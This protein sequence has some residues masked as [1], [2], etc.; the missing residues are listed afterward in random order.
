MKRTPTIATPGTPENDP[1]EKNDSVISV[2]ATLQ[3]V[4][5]LHARI[6]KLEEL[7]L[8]AE[9]QMLHRAATACESGNLDRLDLL[10]LHE[11][12]QHLGL[13]GRSKRWDEV[14][15]VKWADLATE[16][17][18]GR[19]HAPNGPEGTWV[20]T[21]PPSPGDRMPRPRTPVVYVLFDASSEPI[22][23]GS[24]GSLRVRL[25]RHDWDGRQFAAWQAYRTKSR[26]EAYELEVRLLNE[27]LP[28]LNKKRGR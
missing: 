21:W 22:Y 10:D 1:G 6:Q 14:M 25:K 16:L 8:E 24:T 4:E 19:A 28:P 9:V 7:R 2:N 11:R 12:L 15:P 27:R 20:G 5:N 3:H 23:V 26:E 17:R 18:I 13:V